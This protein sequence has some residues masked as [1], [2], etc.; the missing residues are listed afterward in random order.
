VFFRVIRGQTV[1]FTPSQ[2]TTER[3]ISHGLH[4]LARIK[5]FRGWLP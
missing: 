3:F 5:K 4:Q 2:P 1:C